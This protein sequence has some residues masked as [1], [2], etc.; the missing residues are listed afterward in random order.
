MHTGNTKKMMG[1]KQVQYCYA[2]IIFMQ[3]DEADEP[4]KLLKRKSVMAAVR[5]LREWD[6]DEYY[7]LNNHSQRGTSDSYQICLG[8]LLT[9]NFSLGYIGLEKLLPISQS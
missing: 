8:Y 1:E 7:E 3:G 9:W 5:Y 4:L 6:N 2:S